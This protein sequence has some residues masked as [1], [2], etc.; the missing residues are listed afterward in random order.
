[1]NRK[2]LIIIAGPT[3]VGK[4]DISINLA[5]AISGEIISADSVQVYKEMDI[6]SAKISKEEMGGIRHHLI[7]IL[8][9]A[10]DFNVALFKDL[11]YKA[12]EDIYERGHIPILV[13][14]TGFYIQAVLKNVDFSDGASD[15]D[16]RKNL[17]EFAAKEGKE[18]L[19][20]KLKAVDP[21][22]AEAIHSGNVKRVVRALE[23]FKVTG[24]KI[25]VHNEKE[26]NKES[27]F[28]YK[29]FVLNDEREVLYKR[30]DERVD[31]M[32]SAGLLD[33]VKSL[34]DKKIP[35]DAVSMQSLGYRQLFDYLYGDI[36]LDEAVYQIK[37]QTRHFAKRQITW[38]KREKNVTW[39]N[40]NEF[41]RDDKKIL[42][43]MITEC[44]KLLNG[45]EDE[46]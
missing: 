1:M 32:M 29:F 6:G 25:S 34:Y 3:A 16:Y 31:K 46:K 44:N 23:F 35:R 13:G 2:P 40:K 42:E 12:A 39:V 10:D 7:D 8:D 11:V 5:G 20:D 38:F 19:H 18:A 14:G 36:S 37:L 27:E 17:E 45:V 4:T 22:A 28:N 15:P 33:E 30:I 41:G 24:E 21:E 9:P 26:K 43:F